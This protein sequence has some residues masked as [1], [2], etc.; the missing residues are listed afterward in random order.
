M[1]WYWLSFVDEDTGEFLGVVI[2]AGNSLESALRAS[3]RLKLNPGGEALGYPIPD[4]FVPPAKH[5]NRLL[6]KHEAKELADSVGK[7]GAA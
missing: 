2:I 5:R 7:D 4:Q 3:W 1:T 6:E